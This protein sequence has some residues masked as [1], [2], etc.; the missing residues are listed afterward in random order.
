MMSIR[1]FGTRL[2]P[3]ALLALGAALVVFDHGCSGDSSIFGDNPGGG[4]ASSKASGGGEGGAPNA[5]GAG[6]ATGSSGGGVMCPVVPGHDPVAAGDPSCCTKGPA[7]CIPEADIADSVRSALAP[8]MDKMGGPGLCT[9]D[10]QI[11]AGSAF[12]AAKCPSI[13]GADGV[14]LSICVQEVESDP[15]VGLLMRSNCANPDELCVPCINPLNMKSTHA[16]DEPSC[17]PGGSGGG[18]GGGLPC[19]Y[20]G[21]P[22]IDPT[23]LDACSPACAGAHCVPAAS[24]PPAQQALLAAC[25]AMGGPGFCTPDPFIETGGNI[26]PPSCAAFTGTPAEGRCLSTCVA[27]VSSQASQLHRDVCAGGELCAPCYDPITGAA[28]GACSGSPCD[29]PHLPAYQFPTCC[30]F[31]GVDGGTCVPSDIVPA[32]QA[33]NL[34]QDTCPS[35]NFLCVPN[36]YLPNSTTPIGT[37]TSLLGAA[38][39]VSKCTTAPQLFLQ[40]T[41]PDNHQCV[42]CSAAPAGTPGCP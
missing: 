27:S 36:E 15:N 5:G 31:G 6:G 13:G 30:T 34:K 16:C 11:K 3:A 9:P 26:I 19:P 20:T 7:H 41:C 8:C 23:T 37:C 35:N 14:C 17:K 21:P 1:S 4:G 22:L 28:T 38:T 24:V 2:T 39:C 12:R 29:M 42:P 40:D 33:S 18:G 10:I 32:A 25:T